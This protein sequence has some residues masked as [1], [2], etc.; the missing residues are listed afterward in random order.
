[1]SLAKLKLMLINEDIADEEL[2]EDVSF[3]ASEAVFSP[4]CY[5]SL[6]DG[7]VLRQMKERKD[8]PELI[9]NELILIKNNNRDANIDFLS[10]FNSFASNQENNF[11]VTYINS[12]RELKAEKM[13]IEKSLYNKNSKK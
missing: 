10:V 3:A 2:F 6:C 1:M 11:A 5:V 9:E 12:G 13:N 8:L 7:G 4:L